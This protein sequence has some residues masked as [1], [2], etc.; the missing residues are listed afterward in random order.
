MNGQREWDHYL[1]QALS[2]VSLL[3]QAC[4]TS[5]DPLGDRRGCREPCGMAATGPGALD[6]ARRLQSVGSFAHSPVVN[7]RHLS[8]LGHGFR[9]PEKGQVDAAWDETQARL[10]RRALQAPPTPGD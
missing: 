9:L 8:P 10:A 3:L 5:H 6:M 7:L 4:V 1:D 2:R